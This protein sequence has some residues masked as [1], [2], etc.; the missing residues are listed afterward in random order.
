MTTQERLAEKLAQAEAWHERRSAVLR[1]FAASWERT[2][3]PCPVDSCGMSG[4]LGWSL[5]KQ[6]ETLVIWVRY[7]GERS[8]GISVDEA[9]AFRSWLNKLLGPERSA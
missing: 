9:D 5:D 4:G 1:E 3:E 6:D 2:N 7:R 8:F